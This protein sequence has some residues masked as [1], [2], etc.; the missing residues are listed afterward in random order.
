MDVTSID[1][2]ATERRVFVI[3]SAST[4]NLT[5]RVLL[6]PPRCPCDGFYFGGKCRHI[7]EAKR[8]ADPYRI[9]SRH[10]N[11]FGTEFALMEGERVLGFYPSH[12]DALM[13]K[14]DLMGFPEVAA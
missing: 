9:E 8:L 2:K 13:A 1:R 6:D 10:S 4:P 12:H 14:M 5:Y 3:E 11:L 7:A